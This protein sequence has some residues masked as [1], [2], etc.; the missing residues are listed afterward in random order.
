[1]FKDYQNKKGRLTKRDYKADFNLADSD[2]F[3]GFDSK[4]EGFTLTQIILGAVIALP[5]IWITL[6]ILLTLTPNI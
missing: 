4:K 2:D 1:M 5:L 6:V 3:F